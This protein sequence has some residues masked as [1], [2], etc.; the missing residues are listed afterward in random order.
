MVETATYT[1][2]HNPQYENFAVFFRMLIESDKASKLLSAVS[3]INQHNPDNNTFIVN[4]D[5]YSRLEGSPYCYW[6]D[7][8]TINL[9]SK[10]YSLEDYHG[11]VRVGLQ[12]GKD[13]RFLRMFWEVDPSTIVF[14]KYDYFTDIENFLEEFS[15]QL[16]EDKYWVPFSKTDYAAPWFSPIMQLVNWHRDGKEIKNFYNEKGVLRSA[17]RS[18]EYYYHPGFSYM[19]RSTRLVPYI[20]PS[21][22][23]PTAG[24]SQVYANEG[25]EYELLGYCAS[26]V[27]SSVARFSGEAFARPKFQAGMVKSLPVPKLDK[28]TVSR[29]ERLITD[30]INDRRSTVQGYEPCLEFTRPAY[31][32]TDTI[33]D[34]SWNLFTL[35]GETLEMQIAQAL[36]L[37]ERQYDQLIRDLREAVAIRNP[38]DQNPENG[39]DDTQ[40]DTI[41]DVVSAELVDQGDYAINEGLLSYIIGVIVGRWD[42][43][44]ALN[45]SLLPKLQNVFAPLSVCPPGSL[46]STNGLPAESGSIASEAWLRARPDVITLPEITDQGVIN[47]REGREQPATIPN[48][49]YPVSIQWDGILVDDPGLDGKSP[50]PSDIVL[51]VREVLKILWPENHVDVESVVCESLG[52]KDLREYFRKPANF[53][54]DHLDRY[55]KSRRKAPIYWPLSTSSGSYT[56]WIYYQRLSDEILYTAVN[57]YVEP[58]IEST[59]RHIS[60]LEKEIARLS[61]RAASVLKDRIDDAREFIIELREFRDEILRIAALPYKPNL[62]DGVIINAAPFHRLFGLTKW[63]EH[64]ERTWSKLKSG[65]YDWAHLAYAIWPDRVREVCKKDNSIAIAHGLEGL[66]QE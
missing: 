45:Q 19:L 33:S 16:S 29:L 34:T 21:G 15:Y 13:F 2:Q 50:H 44:I 65:E 31:L 26:N 58:K 22:G 32:S 62:N 51:K 47:D 6:I 9:L 8:E 48:S 17:V 38:F 24:R 41:D 37:T 53:F 10:A 55:T 20:V 3:E 59:G 7:G 27:A 39:I 52:M 60:A 46:V 5:D 57:R 49:E 40:E 42:I 61:G 12:T 14:N 4:P 18:P 11:S 35:L 1:V 56:L 66:Y 23:I 25:E 28:D 63:A 54:A 43:R 36:S 30:E 64:T